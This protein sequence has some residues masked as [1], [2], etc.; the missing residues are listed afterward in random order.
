MQTVLVEPAQKGWVSCGTYLVN[1]GI[2][3][4]NI[5]IIIMTAWLR[6]AHHQLPQLLVRQL[7]LQQP[8]QFLN[9]Q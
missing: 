8:L 5:I 7:L 1:T 3:L 6:F 4:S 9:C 2:E